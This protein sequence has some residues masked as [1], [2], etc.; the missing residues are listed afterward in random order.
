MSRSLEI[1]WLKR[2][3]RSLVVPEVA[4]SDL[5]D[6]GGYYVRPGKYEWPLDGKF[7]DCRFGLIVVGFGWSA[8]STIA[9]EW[10]HH[11][12]VHNGWT[13]DHQRFDHTVKWED[14]IRKY[15]RESRSEMDALRFEK[16]VTPKGR[17]EEMF[18]AVFG[19]YKGQRQRETIQKS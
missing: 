14:A 16:L 13:L 2:F 15:F 19:G 10:R 12:Q 4:F 18:D 17:H 8:E 7:I 3:D 5:T 9:H 1:N 6:C 11:W